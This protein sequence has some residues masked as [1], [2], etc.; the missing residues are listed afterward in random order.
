[1]P[2]RRPS[3]CP[4]VGR[5]GELASTRAAGRDGGRTRTGVGVPARELARSLP[6][7][8]H[9]HARGEAGRDAVAHGTLLALA[10]R[11]NIHAG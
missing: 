6:A 8:V 1:V 2:A 10:R 4:T 11:P 9:A 5:H 3:E 7:A